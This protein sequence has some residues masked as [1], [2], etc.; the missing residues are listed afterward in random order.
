MAR[1]RTEGHS[2]AA[3]V[4]ASI[5]YTEAMQLVVAGTVEETDLGKVTAA[6]SGKVD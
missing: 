3:K 5:D 4:G 2:I 6:A 1:N